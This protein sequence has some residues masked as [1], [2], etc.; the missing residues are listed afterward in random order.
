MEPTINDVRHA[1]EGKTPTLHHLTC[2][3]YVRAEEVQSCKVNCVHVAQ[4]MAAGNQPIKTVP[5]FICEQCYQEKWISSVR[6]EI[7]PQIVLMQQTA[8]YK[9]A[10]VVAQDK[11][12]V[13]VIKRSGA[14]LEWEEYIAKVGTMGRQE[15]GVY[16]SM[17]LADDLVREV[18]D[19]LCDMMKIGDGQ[20]ASKASYEP[21][22]EAEG[23]AM[24]LD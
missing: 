12:I 9:A 23:D 21:S 20:M 17:M 19:E 4:E 13:D 10:D 2:G 11:L 14:P 8:Q 16:G 15:G 5:F 24:D 3:H 6:G 1:C 18:E 7:D 22:Q